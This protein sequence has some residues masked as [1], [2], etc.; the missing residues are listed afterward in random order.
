ME[1]VFSQKVNA[2]SD[3]LKVITKIDKFV[4][5]CKEK[6]ANSMRRYEAMKKSR[7]TLLNRIEFNKTL[8]GEVPE[9]QK[10]A[11]K[12]PERRTVMPALASKYDKGIMA[13]SIHDRDVDAQFIL[14]NVPAFK[15]TNKLL[16]DMQ[17]IRIKKFLTIMQ[18]SEKSTNSGV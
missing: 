18:D 12:E 4:K 11:V 17:N 16:K 5:D 9:S 1:N 10:E 2:P 13:N 15:D 7:E 6:N 14:S 8:S 3:K